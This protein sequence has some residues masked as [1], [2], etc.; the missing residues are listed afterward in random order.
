MT[1]L[2]RSG[3]LTLAS[4]IP[5]AGV[6][7]AGVLALATTGTLSAFTAQIT[8]STNTAATGSLVMQETGTTSG[9]AYTCTST[10]A[11]TT[12]NSI[13]TNT[14]TCATI[15]KY[16]G[17]TT[18]TPGAT[19]TVTTVTLTNTGTVAATTFSVTPGACTQ[20]NGPSTNPKGS[21]VDLCSKLN[22][23]ITTGAGAGTAITGGT[24]TATALA[25]K[26]ITLA[27]PVAPGASVTFNFSVQL[28]TTA[29]N[30]YQNLAASQPIVW[31]FTA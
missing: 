20:S 4:L 17:S 30:T 16:S 9:T 27:A 12:A 7:A 3:W 19:P 26:P 31:N 8:N 2:N 25:S 24:G 22:I 23:A 11:G 15:N 10:D 21:A 13:N 14:A 18:L 1:R 6:A 5:V 29:D 28:A